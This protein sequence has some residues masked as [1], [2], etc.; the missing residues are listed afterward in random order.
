VEAFV[1]TRMP[2][3]DR[4]KY[5]VQKIMGV[6]DGGFKKGQYNFA[7]R[8]LIRRII[9]VDDMQL[10]VREFRYCSTATVCVTSK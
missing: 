9:H 7:H 1:Q 6:K 8:V 10:A 4:G 3:E 5:W 2:E